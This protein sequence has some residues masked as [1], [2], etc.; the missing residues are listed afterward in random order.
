MY[1][2]VAFQLKNQDFNGKDTIYDIT[3]LTERKRAS[4]FSGIHEGVAVWPFQAFQNGPT[5]ATITIGPTLSSIIANYREGQYA[6]R[7]IDDQHVEAMHNQRRN[8]QGVE[9]DS[10]LCTKGHRQRENFPNVI[11]PNIN[12]RQCIQL[13]DTVLVL[14]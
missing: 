9:G 4:N 12:V 13:V 11:D 3:C 6:S 1:K 7:E 14:C 5:P 2:I 10:K 8:H